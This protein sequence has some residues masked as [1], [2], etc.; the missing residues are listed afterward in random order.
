MPCTYDL[1]VS[2]TKYF[3]A[4]EGGEVPLLFLFSGTV[5]YAAEDGRLQVQQISWEKECT[6]RMPVSVWQ[7][8][9]DHHYPNSAWLS[10]PRETFDRLYAFKRETGLA[11]WE[12]VDR[13]AAAAAAAEEVV[14]VELGV[15][16]MNAA[17]V[18]QVVAAV[19]Y[20]GYILYPYRAS[21]KKNRQRFTFGRVYPEAYSRAQNG[22]EPCAMQTECLVR[23]RG[24][25]RWKSACVFCSRCGARCWS[26]GSVV[27]EARGGREAAANLAGSGGAGRP[28][29]GGD[30]ARRRLESRRDSAF[31]FAASRRCASRTIRRPW[32]FGAGRRQLRESI[33]VATEAIDADVSKITVR[34][35]N[36]TPVPDEVLADQDAVL[37]RTFAST[38]TILHVRDGEFLSLLEPRPNMPPR[39]AACQNIG[40]VA[41]AGGR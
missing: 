33:E 21:S 23:G 14:A 10:L 4:L 11:T 13:A 38:H 9:M 18:D 19:L 26:T 27:P 15:A 30:R 12:Q 16:A 8:M 24:G 28:G 2:A 17:L 41:G 40:V 39:R 37:M 34:V 36:H 32:R 1:N 5:F 35:V 3:Y 29:A 20:E 6:Y 22:A 31:E 25:G 7:E